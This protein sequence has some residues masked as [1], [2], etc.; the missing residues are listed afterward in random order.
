MNTKQKLD[1]QITELLSSR[2]AFTSY[3]TIK[4][5]KEYIDSLID[6]HNV[7]I[8]ATKH[9]SDSKLK[10]LSFEVNTTKNKSNK[11]LSP[12]FNYLKNLDN[13]AK[14]ME[15]KLCVSSLIE[16]NELYINILNSIKEKIFHWREN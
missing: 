5:F 13:K 14:S 6:S 3:F 15:N 8:S 9:L 12:Y 11:Y 7:V 4:N 2:K 1:K 10:K 16:A